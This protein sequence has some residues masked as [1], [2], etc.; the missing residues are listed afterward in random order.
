MDFASILSYVQLAV[1]YGPIVK[2]IIDEATSND[3]IVQ[4][5]EALAAPVGGMIANLGAQLFP[6][7]SG[8][9][10]TVG[11]AIAAFDPNTTKWLQKS[12]NTMLSPSP[13][14]EV[15]GIY[16]AKTQAAV[17]ALQT[18]LGLTPDG[19]AGKITQAAINAV[20]G[21][22]PKAVGG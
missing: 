15:D 6:K 20:V 5:V 2:Q 11:A 14:L 7:S 3:E 1:Q 4:K 13:N 17:V 19:I 18:K 9:L 16:G 21:A 22:A 12:L 10:Q 8:A